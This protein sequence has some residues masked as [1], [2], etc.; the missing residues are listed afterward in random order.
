M[1]RILSIGP[2]TDVLAARNRELRLGGHEVRGAHT[3]TNALA[4]ASSESFELIVLC[5]RFLLT[6]AE[7]L[8]NELHGLKPQATILLLSGRAKPLTLREITTIL[9]ERQLQAA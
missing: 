4:L 3:R 7:R 1:A 9:E 6:D 2:H 5:D 8:K